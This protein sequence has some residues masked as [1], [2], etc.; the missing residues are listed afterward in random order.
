MKYTHKTKNKPILFFVVV[1]YPGTS[2]VFFIVRVFFFFFFFFF[3]FL[4][5]FFRVFVA[6]WPRPAGDLFFGFV[7]L[8][9]FYLFYSTVWQCDQVAE[10]RKLVALRFVVLLCI[11]NRLDFIYSPSCCH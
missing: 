1:T 9:V 2:F 5:F 10:E 11:C 3:F 7:L 6:L 8:N 4:F